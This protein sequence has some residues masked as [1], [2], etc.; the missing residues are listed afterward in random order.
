MPEEELKHSGMYGATNQLVKADISNAGEMTVSLVQMPDFPAEKYMYT[1]DGSFMSADGNTKVSFVTEENGRTYMWS[2]QYVSL[3]GLGQTAFSHYIAEKLAAHEIPEETA[4]AWKDREGKEY[5]LINE[6]YTSLGYL[7]M[8][9]IKVD[10]TNEAP[11]YVSD[12]KITGPNTAS[13]D[14]QIPALSGRD[15][16]QYNFYTLEGAEYLEAAGSLYVRE[17]AMMPLYTGQKS[18]ATIPESGHAKWYTIPEKGAGKTMKVKL[19]ANSS[20]AV[21]DEKGTCVNF[22]VISGDHKVVLPGKGTVVF[23]GEAGSKFDLSIK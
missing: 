2:R 22:T 14:L 18:S 6:K 16:A 4:A 23:A 7:I 17:D 21:Y 9:I 5:Y 20:F 15:L 10:M 8:P 19:P 12:K 1:A 11:G 13:S 3:P